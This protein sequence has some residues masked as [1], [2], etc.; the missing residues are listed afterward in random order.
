[1]ASSSNRRTL[2]LVIAS[3]ALA[4]VTLCRNAEA[5]LQVRIGPL[6]VQ[7][8]GQVQ[9]AGAAD[10][11]PTPDQPDGVFVRESP[12]AMDTFRNGQRMERLKEW[13][14]AADFYQEVV[15]KYRDR[16][17]PSAQDADHHATQYTS[18]VKMVQEQICKW[19]VEGRAAYLTRYEVVA[20]GLLDGR[21]GN[22]KP[23][24]AV[25]LHQVYDRYFVTDAGKQ[26]GIRLMDGFLES[27]AYRAAAVIGER[28]IT[29]HPGIGTDSAGVLYRT[30][31][32]Y[33]FAGN[34]SAAN[35]MLAKLQA[36]HPLDHGTI[37]GQDVVLL[38]SLRSELK[39]RGAAPTRANTTADADY[40][41]MPWG[42]PSR[43]RISSGIGKP[44][45]HLFSIPLSKPSYANV[46]GLDPATRQQLEAGFSSAV[47]SG[48]TTGVMPVV[49][50]G[51]LFFQDGQ[52]I[53]ARNLESNLPLPGWAITYPAGGDYV[54]SNGFMATRTLQT[55]LTV[56]QHEVLAVM[57]RPD[58]GVTT[59]MESGET[60]N[61]LVCLDRDTGKENWISSP[62]RFPESAAGLRD[63][64]LSGSPLVIGQSV[65]L[66]G[67]GGASKG[68]QFDDTY[69]ISFDLQTG[70]YQWSCYIAS[71]NIG[72]GPQVFSGQADET[73]HLA[74]ADGL[75]YAQTNL[76]AIA[77]VDPFSQSLVWVDVYPTRGG[78]MEGVNPFQPMIAAQAGQGGPAPWT[79]NPVIAS[80][81]AVFTLP[82]EGK[83]LLIYDSTS[84]ALLKDIPL[85]DL[86]D[87]D[88]LLGVVGGRAIV[89]GQKSVVGVDW[90]KYNP[91]TFTAGDLNYYPFAETVR[92]RGFI[93]TAGL[94]VPVRDRLYW[95]DP[96]AFKEL[97]EYPANSHGWDDGQGPGNVVV[98]NTHVI[99]AGATSV[100]VYTDL[101]LARA[102]LDR[103]IAANP[104]DPEPHLRYAVL[105]FGAKDPDAALQRLDEA[106]ALLGGTAP[107]PGRNELFGDAVA[108][109]TALTAD[110][111]PEMHD[112]AGKFFE[113]AE[114]A[115]STP[116]QQIHS[117]LGRAHL[118]AVM[119]DPVTAVKVYQSILSDENLRPVSL[120]DPRT[121]APTQAG[122]LA[123]K[124]I[125]VLIKGNPQPYA[126]FEQ[127]ASDALAEAKRSSDDLPARLLAVSKTYPNSS[128][129][130]QAMLAAADA[131][132]AAGNPRMALQAA[133][134]LY[135]RTPDGSPD[136]PRILETMARNYLVI[137]GRSDVV[138]AA[139]A[140]LA[141]GAMLPGDPVLEKPL[142]LPNNQILDRVRFSQALD[143]VR[144]YS[145]A[146]AIRALPDFG[147]PVPNTAPPVDGHTVRAPRVS[148]FLPLG[149]DSDIPGVAALIRPLRDQ[150]RLDRLV[151]LG[152]N[153]K[154]E[155]FVPGH[156]Q[157][158]A[159]ADLP[160]G[161]TPIGCAWMGS[162]IL[163]WSDS[164]ISMIR[165]DGGPVLWTQELKALPKTE[166]VHAADSPSPAPEGNA[167]VANVNNL[168]QV[169]IRQNGRLIRGRFIMRGMGRANFVVP[170][171]QPPQPLQLPGGPER[172]TQVLP[173]GDHVLLAT[174]GGRIVCSDLAQ[175]A[176][177]WQ[178]H[179]TDQPISRLIANEDF[180]VA[181][182]PDGDAVR[183]VAVDSFSGEMRGSRSFVGGQSQYVPINLALA[184]D[185]T[186]VY[187]LPDRLCLKNLYTPWPDPSDREVLAAPN[188]SP[189]RAGDDAP[190]RPDQL[191][192]AEGRILALADDG[193][194]RVVRIHSLETGQP[195]QLQFTTP[196]GNQQTPR[197][198][199][200]GTTWDVSLRVVG[201][202]LYVIGPDLQASYNL[203]KP[204]EAWTRDLHE[205]PSIA[206]IRDTMFGRNF[207]VIVDG[208]TDR[209]QQ[210]PTPPAY[211][212]RAVGLY[213]SSSATGTKESGKLEYNVPLKDP[214]GL[215]GDFQGLSGGFCY[216][217]ADHHLHVLTGAAQAGK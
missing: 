76:G 84:G 114:T 88:T 23:A 126:P 123:E 128:A 13:G 188:T 166:I 91:K 147:L 173:I 141:Q 83:S 150:S 190:S 127:A 37:R 64:E 29:W 156:P 22:G 11:V 152:T 52:K 20:Q 54:L 148:P 31:L 146:E 102:N 204:E 16:V 63:V 214:A 112:R 164:R 65:L 108:F 100:D 59:S 172:I 169:I 99:V 41:P 200:A 125:A 206:P 25:V 130:P 199:E 58:R 94:F 159:I 62:S 178:M 180:A 69:V 39:D 81:G 142:R 158:L 194:H 111:R 213:P 1:M 66:L 24:D 61:R 187:T 35:G 104:S 135:F 165:E 157:P 185:G 9:I 116:L 210:P 28:L 34:A 193:G 208:P 191:L 46:P 170:V 68:V 78:N 89:T 50:H 32:A 139:A 97:G 207:L 174:T 151:V 122:A 93:T 161:E 119:T 8:Q 55:S 145:G 133:R 73:S 212:L 45:V 3:A 109:A 36:D 40:W 53:Y 215:T 202:H 163:I 101:A 82:A 72:V 184:A 216:L 57:G 4:A 74:Y 5:Q 134:Q 118:A 155:I 131:Y 90:K 140:R 38:D 80:D 209:D 201:S 10:D 44:G 175:G 144:K 132:E 182:F 70:K 48:N 67:H 27:G 47:A 26:A 121:S 75:V 105:M 60:G 186:L 87:C 117:R 176:V 167:A 49:D 136:R 143:A 162:N 124:G 79:S 30:A 183:L 56:T 177:V 17:I 189:F 149:P 115:A 15:E 196:Q 138:A 98:T 110:E 179:V 14:K 113:R 197:Q 19:P 195:I 18:I 77:A 42:D 33:H 153:G 43:S 205:L 120:P 92:G 211:T 95:L 51:D 12:A 2:S 96:N 137:P 168:N 203:D 160:A 154:V 103:V 217:T 107:G 7:G 106:A 21:D 85:S 171:A 86:H 181:L 198:L 192:I 6:Q 129:A 71:A